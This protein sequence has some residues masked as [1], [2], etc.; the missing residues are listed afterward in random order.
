M[1]VLYG[2]VKPRGLLTVGAVVSL[3]VL[4]ALLVD[5]AFD[6]PKSWAE[7]IAIG[8]VIFMVATVFGYWAWILRRASKQELP[9]KD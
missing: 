1:E 9:A 5:A 3:V 2:L 8:V 4:V 6:Y 7:P